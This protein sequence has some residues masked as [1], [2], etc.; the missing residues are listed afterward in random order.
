MADMSKLY[1][2][3]ISVFKATTDW[4]GTENFSYN[5][6]AMTF[7][8][9]SNPLFTLSLRVEGRVLEEQARE[10]EW[11]PKLWRVITIQFN[12]TE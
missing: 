6:W 8:F 7:V 9:T 11:N 10:S 4:S 12:V 1:L 3:S 5:S 2:L